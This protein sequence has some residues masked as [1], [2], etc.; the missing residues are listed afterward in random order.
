MVMETRCHL[1]GPD[2][3][4]NLVRRTF[5]N[6]RGVGDFLLATGLIFV[7]GGLIGSLDGSIHR[8]VAVGA[9][10][11]A[12]GIWT[13]RYPRDGIRRRSR[14]NVRIETLHVRSGGR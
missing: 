14:R 6:T 13:R 7:V 9:A 5:G 1:H 2:P 4:R 11:V 3:T 12:V 10:C 8:I